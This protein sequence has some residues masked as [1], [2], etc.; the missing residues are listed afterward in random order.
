ML[1]ATREATLA[2]SKVL[3]LAQ[4][5]PPSSGESGEIALLIRASPAKAGP[6]R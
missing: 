3:M 1:A 5:F 6:N 4:Y 2:F